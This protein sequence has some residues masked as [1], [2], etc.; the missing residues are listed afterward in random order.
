MYARPIASIAAQI[1]L[2]G[3]FIELRHAA[4]HED[5]PS[6]QVLREGAKEALNWLLHNYWIPTLNGPSS[7]VAT[8]RGIP[9]SP[10]GPLLKEYKSLMKL[11]VRD[12]SLQEQHKPELARLFRTLER[13]ISEAKVA[14]GLDPVVAN[15]EGGEDDDWRE[16]WALEKV[17]LALM[18]KGGLVPVSKKKRPQNSDDELE[19]PPNRAL[20]IPLLT[21]LQETHPSFASQLLGQFVNYFGV[22]SESV[23]RSYESCIAGWTIWVVE[24][25]HHLPDCNP[26]EIISGL[27]LG[28]V[29]RETHALKLL[30]RKLSVREPSVGFKA[31]ILL[32][33]IEQ[34][35]CAAQMGSGE[36]M[37]EEMEKRMDILERVS[38]GTKEDNS[39]NTQMDIGPGWRVLDLQEWKPCPLG[40]F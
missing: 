20:W 21:Q 26:R 7:S 12:A 36:D 16:R 35:K 31:E 6:L 11:S 29:G 28:V 13:W 39:E 25:W 17:C 37:I 33:V 24:T 10:L 4:T 5:L 19:L 32:S 22:P 3:W 15:D 40:M 18:D 23:D 38:E 8:N 14:A 30:I 2:P 27:L 9:L 34:G 1:G